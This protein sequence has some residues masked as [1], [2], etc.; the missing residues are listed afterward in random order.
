M[1][2][3]P[4]SAGWNCAFFSTAPFDKFAP[5]SSYCAWTQIGGCQDIAATAL[6]LTEESG[7]FDL[8]LLSTP[9][10]FWG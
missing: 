5:E 8:A 4:G 9:V 3:D 7:G 6:Y 1:P 2:G 10:H